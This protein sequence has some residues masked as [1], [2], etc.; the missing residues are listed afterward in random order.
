MVLPNVEKKGVQ[1]MRTLAP[2]SGQLSAIDNKTTDKHMRY[3]RL[4]LDKSCSGLRRHATFF[5]RF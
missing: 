4:K 3:C 1:V 5:G 2:G